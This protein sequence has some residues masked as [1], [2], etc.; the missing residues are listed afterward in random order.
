MAALEDMTSACDFLTVVTEL[1]SCVCSDIWA[2]VCV[3]TCTL[4]DSSKIWT[5]NRDQWV[6]TREKG[7]R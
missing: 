5:T 6:K 2:A 7:R 1:G 3:C 4:C